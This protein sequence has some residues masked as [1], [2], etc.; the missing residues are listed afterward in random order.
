M[1]IPQRRHVATDIPGPRSRRLI[2]RRRSAVPGGLANLVPVFVARAQGAIVEDVDGNKFIDLAT[3]ISVLNLGHSPTAVIRAINQQSELYTHTC[4]S[5]A[6][7]EPYLELASE[8]NR[9]IPGN[10]QKMTVLLNSG[11]EGVENA[12]KIARFFTRRPGVAVFGQSFHGRT[13]LGM[14]LTGNV[15]P[16]K[17]GFGPLAPDVYRLPYS[18]PY[19]CP[20]G[21]AP[22]Q[23]GEA[24]ARNAIDHI[25]RFIGPENLACF[26]MEPVQGEGGFIVPQVDFLTMLKRYCEENG[27]VFIA[28]EVQT[29]FART[30]KWFAIEHFGIEPDMVVTAKALGGGI[31]LAAVTGTPEIMDSVHP[32]GLGSTFGGNPI[33]CSAALAVL[34]QI[35]QE[36]LCDR[37]ARLGELMLL[38]LSKLQESCPVIGEVRGLGAMVG[39]ELV[40]DPDT[41]QPAQGFTSAV[42]RHCHREGVIVLRAGSYENVIRLLP[43]LTIDE[44]LLEEGLSIIEEAVL[45][46]N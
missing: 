12:V 2:A 4:F 20:S 23:C 24:C 36:D 10:G 25:E 31:P 5:V 42:L 34:N 29:A 40:S 16:Y 41:K 7:N 9:L 1:H 19:R 21:A 6:M 18:Y 27:I 46:L 45:A 8:L 17:R 38:R 37:S 43:P 26:V 30:G 44:E 33:A 32:G 11:A 28:D 22:P 14:T 13:L 39:L 3:G 15:L 35:Q